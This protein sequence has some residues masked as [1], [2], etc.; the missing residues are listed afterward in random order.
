MD[1]RRWAELWKDWAPAIV[2]VAAIA[3][4]IVYRLW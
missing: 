3:L 1:T 2:G 4:L